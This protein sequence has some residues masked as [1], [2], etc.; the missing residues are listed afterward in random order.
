MIPQ[1]LKEW[2]G[3]DQAEQRKQEQTRTPM[4]S[5]LI[6][7]Q[8]PLKPQE[9]GSRHKEGAKEAELKAYGLFESL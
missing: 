4:R 1:N 9:T 2:M 5:K 6:A 3:N 7:P 8:K